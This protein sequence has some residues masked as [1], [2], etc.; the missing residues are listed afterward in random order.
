MGQTRLCGLALKKSRQI[1]PAEGLLHRRA[2]FRP[3]RK[4][5][6][7]AHNMVGRIGPL[8][9]TNP[10]SSDLPPEILS[11]TGDPQNKIQNLWPQYDASELYPAA[12]DPSHKTIVN[13]PGP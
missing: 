10:N 6:W 7:G 11:K 4:R 13:I 2:K 12:V 8:R 3:T 1:K 9:T 5:L